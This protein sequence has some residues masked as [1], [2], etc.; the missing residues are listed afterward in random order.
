[1]SE[2]IP[3]GFPLHVLDRAQGKPLVPSTDSHDAD[4]LAELRAARFNE[5][6]DEEEEEVDGEDGDEE[7]DEDH[8]GADSGSESDK[9]VPT[10]RVGPLRESNVQTAGKRLP[11]RTRD[12]DP[13]L[14]E[15]DALAQAQ[16][17]Q[18]GEAERHPIARLFAATSTCFDRIYAK[19]P[20]M[21]RDQA[22]IWAPKSMVSVRFPLSPLLSPRS[23][24][25]LPS[26]SPC[27][28]CVRIP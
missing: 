13:V 14:A 7:E 18:P 1:M 21:L 11:P 4:L 19:L 26:S 8:S 2:I 6:S 25:S 20:P 9:D 28:A 3:S 24:P 16:I 22:D 5:Y 15:T 27:T 23:V 12:H 10:H 17:L